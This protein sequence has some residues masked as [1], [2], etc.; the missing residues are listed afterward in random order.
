MNE[1]ICA[2]C[3]SREFSYK[4]GIVSCWYCEVEETSRDVEERLGEEE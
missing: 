3:G 2:I 4:A 1:Y